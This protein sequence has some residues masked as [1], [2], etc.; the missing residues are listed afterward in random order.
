MN[1]FQQYETER[2][3]LKVGKMWICVDPSAVGQFIDTKG[4]IVQITVNERDY[5][6][7]RCISGKYAGASFSMVKCNFNV[8]YEPY[9]GEIPTQEED[10]E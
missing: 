8:A 6:R 3:H 1:Y 2:K 10:N 4:E 5:C 9:T 7:F